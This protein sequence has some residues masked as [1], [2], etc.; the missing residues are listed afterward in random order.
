MLRKKMVIVALCGAVAFSA[1]LPLMSIGQTTK[2]APATSTA[3]AAARGAEDV[4]RDLQSTSQ[5]LGRLAPDPLE[6]LTKKAD[7]KAEIATHIKKMVT[8]LEELVATKDP[9]LG[10]QGERFL[11]QRYQLWTML[12]ALGDADTTKALKATAEGKDATAALNAK[13]S[14]A[15]GDWWIAGKDEKA[16]EK[17]LAEVET[18]AKAN[19]G[20]DIVAES[21][22]AMSQMG[23]ANEKLSRKAEDI[24]AGTLT[25][26]A[27]KAMAQQIK[28][29]RAI[30]ENVGKA[31]ALDG[32]TVEGKDFKL[33][34]YKGKVVLIDFWATWCGP[35]IREL[36]KIQKL[37]KDY[38]P[39]GLEIVGVSCDEDG[40]A[41][42]AFLEK[43]KET[44]PWVQLYDEGQDGW[45]ALATKYSVTAIPTLFLIDR[46]GKL[47]HVDARENTEEKIKALLEEKAAK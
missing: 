45:H 27:A 3:P 13:M 25:G 23:A 6:A 46:E 26:R 5:S 39:K 22:A 41:L 4:M 20:S 29:Q 24:I 12:Y 2:E 31:I 14:L 32:K 15:V 47:R 33:A 35:C 43:N 36:P 18:L 37:Y 21:L 7:E 16:Q 11:D 1:V 8:L 10:G 9:R 34:D 40:K 19:P 38:N 42:K 28:A 44:M 30:E 17:I